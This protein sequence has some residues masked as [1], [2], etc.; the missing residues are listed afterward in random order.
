MAGSDNGPVVIPGD[1]SAS[2]LVE[3]II[4]GDMPRRAPKLPAAEID[5]ISAWV[6]AGALDN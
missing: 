2:S 1:A 5:I 6:D 4:S 3:L